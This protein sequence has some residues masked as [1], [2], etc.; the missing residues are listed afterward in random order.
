[1]ENN[2]ICQAFRKNSDGSW[3]SIAS[4]SIQRAEGSIQVGPNMNFRQGA[5]LMGLDLATW[6]DENCVI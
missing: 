5:E 6:L 3:T 1:M 2:N 4:V